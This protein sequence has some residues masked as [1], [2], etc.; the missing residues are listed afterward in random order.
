MRRDEDLHDALDLAVAPDDGVQLLL[1][2]LLGEVAA[3]LVQH[4]GAGGLVARAAAGGGSGL[5]AGL[6][7]AGAAV[8]GQE[9]DD[10]LAHA[11]QVGAELD[12]HLG[13][14]ALAL[15][16]EAEE[17]VLGADVVVAELEGLAEAQLQDLLGARRE[18][19][20]P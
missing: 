2:G 16:D 4:E 7:R 11:G 1:A 17:D 13:G 19:D 10:L 14:D 20:V 6:A 3:E 12:E 9:L 15:T 18:R 5:V 8:A